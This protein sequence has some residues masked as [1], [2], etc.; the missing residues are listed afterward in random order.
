[1]LLNCKDQDMQDPCSQGA[2]TL[3]E[4]TDNKQVNHEKK[5]L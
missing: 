4:E 1:M 2:H 5:I 3:I